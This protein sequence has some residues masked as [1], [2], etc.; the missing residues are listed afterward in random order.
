MPIFSVNTCGT[1]GSLD[2]TKFTVMCCDSPPGPTCQ[3]SIEVHVTSVGKVNEFSEVER[4]TVVVTDP[5]IGSM[6]V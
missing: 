1:K 6:Y 5:N 4:G 3:I 2:H